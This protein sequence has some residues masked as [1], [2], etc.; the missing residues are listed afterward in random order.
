[1]PPDKPGLDVSLSTNTMQGVP[2]DRSLGN[3]HDSREKPRSLSRI[4]PRVTPTHTQ[5]DRSATA[6]RRS[7]PLL[8]SLPGFQRTSAPRTRSGARWPRR[9]GLGPL[10]QGRGVSVRSVPKS[11]VKG[12]TF[13]LFFVARRPAPG[14]SCGGL[15]RPLSR[16]GRGRVCSSGRESTAKVRGAEKKSRGTGGAGTDC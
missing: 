4:A 8:L 11:S 14:P 7:K 1:M 15:G 13:A 12:M 6:K 2:R 10:S 3:G 16:D 9:E 5:H